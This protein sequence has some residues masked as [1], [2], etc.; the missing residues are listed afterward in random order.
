M[1]SDAAATECALPDG[2]PPINRTFPLLV[3]SIALDESRI[4]KRR[5][6]PLSAVSHAH[7]NKK[8]SF[9]VDFV[10]K[11]CAAAFLPRRTQPMTRSIG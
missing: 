5:A 11:K 3:R 10:E 8:H 6:I 2:L 7:V 1:F 4:E 9:H